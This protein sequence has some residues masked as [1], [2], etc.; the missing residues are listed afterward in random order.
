MQNVA[1]AFQLFIVFGRIAIV[2]EKRAISDFA[3]TIHTFNTNN[4]FRCVVNILGCMFI[5]TN[6]ASLLRFDLFWANMIVE[7]LYVPYL[8][9]TCM[10]AM[11]IDSTHSKTGVWQTTHKYMSVLYIPRLKPQQN[12][13]TTVTATRIHWK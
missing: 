7:L 5:F 13:L 4:N 2:F 11:Q 9:Y 12:V 1:Q 8:P 3:F 6:L 10:N